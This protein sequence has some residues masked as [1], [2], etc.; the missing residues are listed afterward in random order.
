MVRVLLFGYNSNVAFETSILGVREQAENL[1]NRLKLKRRDAPDR[2]IAFVAHSLGGIVVKQALVETKLNATYEAIGASTCGLVFF[3][4]PHQGGKKTGLGDI[5][6]TL[7]RAV[8]QDV[9]NSFMESLKEDRLFSNALN[10]NFKHQL[11]DRYI[12]SFYETKPYKKHGLKLGLIVD[13]KSAT[14]GLPGT[15]ETSIGLDSDHDGICKFSSATDDMYEQVSGNIIDLVERAVKDAEMRQRLTK[16]A[17]PTATPGYGGENRAACSYKTAEEQLKIAKEQLQ[18]QKHLAK[19]RLSEKEQECHQLFRLTDNNR[20]ATYERYKD[21]VAE[22]VDGTCMWLL[23]HEHFRSWLAQESG[24]LLITADPGCGKSVLAKYLIDHGLPRSSNI[25]YFFFQDHDQNTVRQALCALLH[26]LFYQQPSLI[27]YALPYY[28]IDG[29]GLINSTRSLWEILQTAIQDSQARPLI[30]VLDALDECAEPEFEDLMRKIKSQ[31]R[32]SQPGSSSL[33]YILMS[34]PYGQITSQFWDLLD[35]FPKIRIPGEEESETISQEVDR[36]ITYRLNQLQTKDLTK[37]QAEGLP[38][39]IKKHLQKRLQETTHRTYLWVYLVFDYLAKETFKKTIKGVDSAIKTLPKSI[40]EAYEQILS[41]SKEYATV[42]KGDERP[43]DFT[44]LGIVSQFGHVVLVRQ[45]LE[46]GAE[47]DARDSEYG[48]TPLLWAAI[49]G[50]EAVVQLLLEKGA[51][52]EAK[53]RIFK[54]TPLAY[55]ADSG[56]KAMVKLLLESGADVGPFDESGQTPL[57]WANEPGNEAVV[58]LLLE[59]QASLE[60]R[61]R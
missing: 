19:E 30:V 47:V 7:T 46:K 21:R 53:D 20:D 8:R 43:T 5:A 11:E 32:S 56:N 44:P 38:P 10:D 26:Q 60:A 42:R 23:E 31:V 49:S 24:P 51:D 40:N 39:E 54:L 35:A 2:P 48:R 28:S 1:L 4:T 29:K 55:A 58:K 25:C 12:I 33:K 50:H 41:K 16:L 36:V 59:A 9:T 15:R 45:L 52:I 57:S 34:R 27:Q 18:A 13:K 17:L 61:G 22:R 37:G 3:G 6:A 14:L